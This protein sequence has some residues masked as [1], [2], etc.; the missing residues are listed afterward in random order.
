MSILEGLFGPPGRDRFASLVMDALRARGV[1]DPAFDRDAF[2]IRMGT[3]AH[4]MLFLGNFYLHFSRAARRDR[5]AV[6]EATAA[7]WLQRPTEPVTT[8]DQARPLLRPS[9]RSRAYYEVSNLRLELEDI[10]TRLSPFGTIGTHV[11]LSLV[12]DYPQ[13]VQLATARD[14]ETWGVSFEEA[15]RVALGNLR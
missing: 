6:V 8:F 12:L 1:A 2:A 15:Y 3:G 13:S 4:E 9:L 5:A 14:L 10:P 7:H 11:A